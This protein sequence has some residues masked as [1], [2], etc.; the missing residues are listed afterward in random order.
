MD[1]QPKASRYGP[2]RLLRSRRQESVFGPAHK[3][4]IRSEAALIEAEYRLANFE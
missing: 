1:E 2:R 3:L 4:R